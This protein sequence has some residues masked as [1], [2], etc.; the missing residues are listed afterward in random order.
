MNFVNTYF[1]GHQVRIRPGF[2]KQNITIDGKK[3]PKKILNYHCP[4]INSSKQEMSCIDGV[5]TVKSLTVA[6]DVINMQN[7]KIFI[8]DHDIEQIIHGDPKID[9]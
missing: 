2:L 5:Y 1:G 9:I 7:G 3:V 8:N 6:N 4:F